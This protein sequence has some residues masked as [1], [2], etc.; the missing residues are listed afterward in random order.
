MNQKTRTSFIFIA[1]V[2]TLFFMLN[3]CATDL[4][5]GGKTGTERSELS[6][7]TM[8][9]VEG[10]IRQLVIGINTTNRALNAL[11]NPNQKEIEKAYGVYVSSVANLEKYSAT[12]LEN[13]EKMGVQGRDYFDEWRIQGNT[14][15][16]RQIQALSEQRRNELSDLY[17]EISRSSVGVKGSLNSY[18]NSIKEIKTYFSTDLTP[19]G[20]ETITPFAL[21]T[22]VDGYALNDSFAAV[23]ES[24]G[25]VRSELA[26][27]N[28]K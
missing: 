19:R 1:L 22:I 14:Y 18:L 15:V 5:P 4:F 28:A 25:T 27:G 6:S 11:T 16:N 23:L 17:S 26:S 8:E 13:S 2:S 3:S 10:N 20:V 24:I 21:R 12:Y 7:N 9:K